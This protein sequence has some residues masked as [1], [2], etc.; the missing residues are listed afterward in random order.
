[1]LFGMVAKLIKTDGLA[2]MTNWICLSVVSKLSLKMH[3]SINQCHA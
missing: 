2:P 3:D 1:M